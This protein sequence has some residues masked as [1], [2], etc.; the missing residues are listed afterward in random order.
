MI[1]EVRTFEFGEKNSI[2]YESNVVSVLSVGVGFGCPN[3]LT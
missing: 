3:E 1:L 2:I